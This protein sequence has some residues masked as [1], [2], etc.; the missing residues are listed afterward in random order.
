M[1]VFLAVLVLLLVFSS[2]AIAAPM[3]VRVVSDINPSSPGELVTF[4]VTGLR[5]N[6]T[7]YGKIESIGFHLDST[8]GTAT[9]QWAI[10]SPGSYL[11]VVDTQHLGI[12]PSNKTVASMTQVVR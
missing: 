7:F 3:T 2:T 8:N 4:T 6:Q 12:H 11:V 5:D 9:F 10:S 1:K